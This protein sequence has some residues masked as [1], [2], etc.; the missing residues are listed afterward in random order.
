M[1][2][3]TK[4]A[5]EVEQRLLLLSANIYRPSTIV[6]IVHPGKAPDHAYRPCDLFAAAEPA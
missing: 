6:P 5:P 2:D 4:L 1:P 3:D